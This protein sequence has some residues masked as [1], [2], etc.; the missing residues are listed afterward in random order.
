MDGQRLD[1]INRCKEK[2]ASQETSDLAR[3]ELKHMVAHR[4]QI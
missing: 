4:L 2:N 3:I 1:K